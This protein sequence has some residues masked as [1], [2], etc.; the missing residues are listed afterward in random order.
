MHTNNNYIKGTLLI[1]LLLT[2]STIYAQI[3]GGGGDVNDE[4]AAPIDGLIALALAIGGVIGV[5]KLRK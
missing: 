4:P 5:K 1:V 2:L 3:G